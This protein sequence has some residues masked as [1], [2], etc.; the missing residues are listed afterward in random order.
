[1]PRYPTLLQTGLDTEDARELAEFYRRL[2]GLAYRAG[3]EPEPTQSERD[4]LVLVDSNGGRALAFQQMVS[5][6]RTTWP[7]SDVPM[8]LH[9]D[10]TVHDLEELHEQRRRAEDL[11]AQLLLDR[12]T[13]PDEPLYVLRDPAGHPFC[14]FVH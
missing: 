11:G 2:L 14:L 5:L 4:W 6:P 12:S 13:D 3:D 9:L 7:T 1:M 10:M 8:Q